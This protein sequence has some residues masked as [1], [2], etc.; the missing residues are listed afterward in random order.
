MPRRSLASWNF[1]LSVAFGM[2]WFGWQAYVGFSE[3]DP[4]KLR[5]NRI[6]LG[7]SMI[8]VIELLL[9]VLYIR[10]GELIGMVRLFAALM[11]VVQLLQIV[12]GAIAGLAEGLPFPTPNHWAMGYLALSNIVYAIFG[13]GRPRTSA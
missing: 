4:T 3:S 2:L 6:P 8:I 11:G 1:L 10:G 9:V 12:V 5:I 13:E 7:A